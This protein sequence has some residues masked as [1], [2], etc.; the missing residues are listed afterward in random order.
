MKATITTLAIS[1]TISLIATSCTTQSSGVT[2]TSG[3]TRATGTVEYGTVNRVSEVTIQD[4]ESGAGAVG[5][6]IAGG[7]LGSTI[8]SGGGSKIASV[9]GAL[10]G[11]AAGNKAEKKMRTNAG[12]ELEIKKDDGKIISV[13]QEADI[14]FAV[15]DRVRILTAADKTVRVTKE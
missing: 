9:A 11:A 3:Q 8:G 1:L 7:V 4:K 14:L 5:G 2:Y 6:G 12:L 15:G 10:I 13:V